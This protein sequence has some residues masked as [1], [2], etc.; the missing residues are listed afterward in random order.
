MSLSDDL[1]PPRRPLFFPVV[2]AT[3]FLSIIGMSAGFAL[4]TRHNNA[5]DIRG[6]N[7]VPGDY[8]PTA[9]TG[10][11][12]PPEMHDTARRLGFAGTLTQVLRVRAADTGTTVW[13]CRDPDGKL[14]YQANRGGEAAKWIEGE[15]AL[16][17]SDVRQDGDTYTAVAHDG[18]TFSVND[19]EL[20]VVTK[21]GT[22][23]HD[24][25]PE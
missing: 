21:R 3:V 5:R 10:I 2:I 4:G 15:T 9:D 25:E 20:T 23:T 7:N 11:D 8:T 17:L 24:V 22:E 12:C 6:V 19:H 14:F 16:F 1:P 18:N 13:I